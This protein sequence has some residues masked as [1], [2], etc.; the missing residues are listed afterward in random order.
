VVYKISCHNC[1]VTYVDQTKHHLKT[2]IQE[3]SADIKKKSGPSS[4]ISNGIN[5]NHDFN[6]SNI[7]ILN[8][9]T[10]KD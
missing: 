3:H 4:V 10:K 7:K 6:W 9:T 1:E 5:D 2:R 8:V